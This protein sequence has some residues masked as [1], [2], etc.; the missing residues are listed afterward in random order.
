M[1]SRSAFVL[2]ARR[3]LA[4]DQGSKLI[5]DPFAKMFVSKDMEE[6]A[7][8]TDTPF[9]YVLMRHRILEDFALRDSKGPH[10]VI[11]LGSGFDTKFL[12]YSSNAGL[13]IIEVDRNENVKYK[14]NI[15]QSNSLPCPHTISSNITS[16]KDL[17]NIF[18]TIDITKRT[19]ILAEGFFMYQPGE[20]FFEG[21]N[22]I[23]N[24]FKFNVRIGFDILHPNYAKSEQNKSITKR[25][26]KN[27]EITHFYLPQKKCKEFFKTKNYITEI[28][29]PDDLQK[30]YYNINWNG[31]NDKYVCLAYSRDTL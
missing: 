31:K 30:K 1:I 18:S 3:W 6:F 14:K 10:N 16:T 9:H 5:C 23:I 2:A 13:T 11:L 17:K 29:T 15:L 4:T 20:F 22:W 21:L 24:Y 19:T 25:L 27:K 8:K 12:R 28:L 26:A 7:K